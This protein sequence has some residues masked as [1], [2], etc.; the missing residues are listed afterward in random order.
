MLPGATSGLPDSDD[1]RGTKRAS[2]KTD[3]TRAKLAEYEIQKLWRGSQSLCGLQELHQPCDAYPY[4]QT[5]RS[6]SFRYVCGLRLHCSTADS[7]Q[8]YRQ[9]AK[10]EW[11]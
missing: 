9:P 10:S 3:I 7:R 6:A 2:G 4:I 8:L 1:E 5:N 11:S